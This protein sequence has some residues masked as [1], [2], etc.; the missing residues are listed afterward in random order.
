MNLV[1]SNDALELL[2]KR[3]EDLNK[4]AINN[5][6]QN[7]ISSFCLTYKTNLKNYYSYIDE[8]RKV[9][10][11]TYLLISNL[12]MGWLKEQNDINL[13]QE[14]SKVEEVSKK[15]R[16]VANNFGKFSEVIDLI[17]KI[18]YFEIDYKSKDKY[19][20]MVKYFNEK[21]EE[22]NK[23]YTFENLPQFRSLINLR[24][25]LMENISQKNSF[26]ETLEEFHKEYLALY[27]IIIRKI[28]SEVMEKYD[29][30]NEFSEYNNVIIYHRLIR[31]AE[32]KLKLIK[33]D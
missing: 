25:L 33:L 1:I 2:E 3:L 17:N 5:D 15:M 10:K 27:K 24:D 4:L 8:I 14:L 11:E 30:V 6:I 7:A 9:Y 29:M 20:L 21:K 13:E 18:C 26:A 23:N 19:T 28:N 12:L 22:I 16:E 32:E 31:S